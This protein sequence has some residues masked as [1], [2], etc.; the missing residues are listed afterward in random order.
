MKRI[1]FFELEDQSWLPNAI[2]EGITDYLQYASDRIRLYKGILPVL[3]KG[4]DKS[5]NN[6]II[7]LCSG[8]GGGMMSIHRQLQ[9]E[10]IEAEIVLTDKF[11][12]VDAFQKA[13]DQSEG[14]IRFM[15]TPVDAVNVPKELHGFR[16]QFV[17][18]HH[19][20]P[21]NAQRILTNAAWQKEP[22]GIFEATE[23]S[24]TNL[25][26]MLFT[27]FVVMLAIPFIRPFKF[28]RLF[29]T[30]VIPAIPLATMWDGIVSVLRTYTLQELREMTDH[31]HVPGYQWEVGRIKEK[32]KPAVLYL[33]GYPEQLQKAA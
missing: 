4:I 23:R 11:P 29:F 14:K 9:A 25:L 33:L 10:N 19:F 12:N 1:H 26:A 6:R 22:I 13:S 18:F 3:R 15:K 16:T 2:R 5:G 32:G 21:K 8:G 28:S 7:D 17:S 30:F 31:I 20:D 24:W 27:P